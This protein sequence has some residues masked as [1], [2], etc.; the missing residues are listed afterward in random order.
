MYIDKPVND[1][2]TLFNS[3]RRILSEVWRRESSLLREKIIRYLNIERIGTNLGVKESLVDVGNDIN[4]LA[5][6]LLIWQI[7]F[8]YAS[9]VFQ[10]IKVRWLQQMARLDLKSPFLDNWSYCVDAAWLFLRSF[11]TRRS[12][13]LIAR[14]LSLYCFKSMSLVG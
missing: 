6:V 10:G 4:T 12:S 1:N 2:S 5:R 9:R 14:S 8:P 13:S 3:Y 11:G 7:R